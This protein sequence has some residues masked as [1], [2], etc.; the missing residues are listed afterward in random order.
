MNN[1]DKSKYYIDSLNSA[2]SSEYADSRKYYFSIYSILNELI[3]E[4]TAPEKQMFT[5]DYA[6]IE[7]IINKYSLSEEQQ[8]DLKSAQYFTSKFRKQAKAQ[9]TQ[10]EINLIAKVIVE[11]VFSQFGAIDD[12]FA[13]N[14][15]KLYARAIPYQS[16]RK[17]NPEVQDL[18]NCHIV[19]KYEETSP[20]GIVKYN[21]VIKTSDDNEIVVPLSRSWE[22]L[23]PIF[24][25]GQELNILGIESKENEDIISLGKNALIVLEPDIMMDVTELASCFADKD[26]N[27]LSYFIDILGSTELSSKMFIGNIVNYIFD[28]LII[29]PETDFDTIY[30]KALNAKPLTLFALSKNKSAE[31]RI[32][33]T[34]LANHYANL[35]SILPNIDLSK[36]S[37]EPSFIS[38]KYGMQG[39]LDLLLESEEFPLQKD[40]VELKS[41]KAPT[42]TKTAMLGKPPKAVPIGM[43]YNNF[44]Q[45]TC[46][47][48]L[49]DSAFDGRTGNS[50]ILYSSVANDAYRNAV[51]SKY[52]KW[53]IVHL[54]NQ[55]VVE[56]IALAKGNTRI[57]DYLMNADVRDLAIFTQNRLNQFRNIYD[58]A[59]ELEKAYFRRS[60]VF[61]QR[62][63]LASQIGD[64]ARNNDS[65]SALWKKS[66]EE[67]ENSYSMISHLVLDDDKSD[68]N[69]Y[70]LYFN[71]S[72]EV[73]LESSFRK[74]DIVLLYPYFDELISPINDQLIKCVIK[75]I[76]G[77]YLV[78]SLRNK[79]FP[80][81]IFRKGYAYW[82]IEPDRNESNNKRLFANIY[83]FLNASKSKKDLLLG[84]QAPQFENEIQVPEYKDLNEVQQSIL[85]LAATAKNYFLVQGPPGTGKTSYMLR[86]LIKYKIENSDENLLLMAY[87]NRAVDEICDVLVKLGEGFEFIRLGSRES[88]AHQ[89]NLICNLVEQQGVRQL[90]SGI[91]KIRI[92]VSTI[93]SA[94]GN[95]EIFHL[96]HFHTAIIDEAAQVLEPQI[97]G[98]ISKV[99]KFIMIGDEKQ[100]P[101][102]VTQNPEYLPVEDELLQNVELRNM[103]VSL[104]ERLLRL[105]LK[106][107]WH[108]GYGILTKQARMHELIQDFPNQSFYS[109]KLSILNEQSWQSMPF[110]MFAE[111]IDNEFIHQISQHR[112]VFVNS[113]PDKKSKANTSEAEFAAKII[114]AYHQL[115]GDGFTA[116]TVGV[117]SPFRVQCTDIANRIPENIRHQ[118]SVDTVE[119][120]QGSERRIIIYSFA[121]NSPALLDKIA[122]IVEIGDAVIDRKLNVAL[123]RAKEQIIILGRE[124]VL[125][126]NPI[127][128]RMI[129]FIK[130][131]GLY[132]SLIDNL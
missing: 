96:K 27:F 19:D 107:D 88:S 69:N 10:N 24:E 36:A 93:F 92:F 84:L 89:N 124:D 54:R 33:L 15:F 103:G 48:M 57:I 51:N 11:L 98:L 75:E 62:E 34:H 122:S 46:Y 67:K 5:S 74:G 39:R 16:K 49:L 3:A 85:N 64:R 14:V 35:K 28:E 4:I 95:S 97:I 37:I 44:A 81:G 104:F 113:M 12:D 6:R 7:F 9:C 42:T 80:V 30:Q 53:Q 76:S 45:V 82:I 105:C 132:L 102:I 65:Y 71:R 47:N 120:F 86:H 23:F 78:L 119:R 56:L 116:E 91:D 29:E 101:A 66:I 70:H 77:E 21:I 58:A 8:N 129:E 106:N 115:L 32:E 31:L 52:T 121:T 100:L 125:N 79:L 112:L 99:D 20:T 1:L 2:Y 17:P 87:T 114:E 111:Q 55:I 109:G 90:Y 25:K 60:I 130:D 68:F 13:N 110:D 40:V 118:V 127:Y 108:Q 128:S 38:A 123:T 63:I 26:F 18:Y 94:I 73:S 83:E 61:I 41:G 72:Q 126:R 22:Y 50:A 117:I 43:W 131:R 59:T